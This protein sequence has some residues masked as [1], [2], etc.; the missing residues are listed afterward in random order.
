M[1]NVICAINNEINSLEKNRQIMMLKLD[2]HNL[3]I[4]LVCAYVFVISLI[5][6]FVAIYSSSY[7]IGYKMAL[8]DYNIVEKAQK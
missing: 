7:N 5:L 2:N 4:Q 1:S 6:G 3:K 8:K